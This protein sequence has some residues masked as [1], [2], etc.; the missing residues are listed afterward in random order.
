[1]DVHQAVKEGGGLVSLADIARAYG[2]S[3]S[4]V[5]KWR[6]REDFPKP[7]DAIAEETRQSVDVWLFADVKRWYLERAAAPARALMER[8]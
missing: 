4:A 2:V 6:E 8:P 5:R 3:H 1:M 7:L